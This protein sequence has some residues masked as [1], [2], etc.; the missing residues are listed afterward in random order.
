MNINDMLNKA[1]TGAAQTTPVQPQTGFPLENPFADALAGLD[2]A[3]NKAASF[4]GLEAGQYMVKVNGANFKINQNGNINLAVEYQVID[5]AKAG[6]REWQHMT[7]KFG[8]EWNARGIGD[9]ATL[10]SAATGS[11]IADAKTFVTTEIVKFVQSATEKAAIDGF[12]NLTGYLTVTKTKSAGKDG[13][14]KE[15]TNYKFVKA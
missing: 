11:S 6:R 5:G 7:M 13:V 10:V 3:V 12:A 4:E 9:F 8:T 2:V 14:E 1:A 15:Y